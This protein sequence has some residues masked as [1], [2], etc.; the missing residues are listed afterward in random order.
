MLSPSKLFF[1][2]PEPEIN[3]EEKVPVSTSE[4]LDSSDTDQRTDV[5]AELSFDAS[6]NKSEEDRWSPAGSVAASAVAAVV[7]DLPPGTTAGQGCATQGLRLE[8]P[9][10]GLPLLGTDELR[11]PALVNPMIDSS[12]MDEDDSEDGDDITEG[13]LFA[14]DDLG[15]VG[16]NPDSAVRYSELPSIGSANHFSG[17]CDR[18][19]FHPKGRCLNGFNCQH[20]HFD[21]EKRK[22]KNKK[23]N[24]TKTFQSLGS[25]D[26]MDMLSVTEGSSVPVSPGQPFGAGLLPESDFGAS[27]CATPQGSMTFIPAKQTMFYPSSQ[28]PTSEPVAAAPNLAD[29]SQWSNGAAFCGGLPP[30][31]GSNFMMSSTSAYDMTSQVPAS[32]RQPLLGTAGP[33]AGVAYAQQLSIEPRYSDKDR[34]DE[35]IHQLESENRYLRACLMQCLGP[36][37]A[38]SMLPPALAGNQQPGD[39][40]QLPVYSSCLP[41]PPPGEPAPVPPGFGTSAVPGATSGQGNLSAN[42]LPF[43]PAGQGA[44][45]PQNEGAPSPELGDAVHF[46]SGARAVPLHQDA[47]GHIVSTSGGQHLT[48]AGEA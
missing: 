13:R 11:C 30:Q 28:T 45:S 29:T 4:C 40:Q 16:T 32:P 23:K 36:S 12:L 3:T 38:A 35:Y 47:E 6:S 48:A 39:P 14:N 21:H 42:A 43:W 20:C 41:P 25:E 26:G 8:Q 10:P 15:S 31:D 2:T 34:R 19:C 27:A 44:W 17:N 9:P 22:R 46:D 37:A 5:P 1:G 18:C 24:K 7:D 33:V